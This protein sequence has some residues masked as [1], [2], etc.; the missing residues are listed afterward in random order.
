[1]APGTVTEMYGAGMAAGTVIS[2]LPLTNNIKGT[3]VLFGD[4][5]PALFF[6]S[7]GQLDIQTPPELTPGRQY[8]VIVNANGPPAVGV[9]D[10]TP[11]LESSASPIG[12]EPVV[13]VNE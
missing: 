10:R 3:S 4:R 7:P 11:E 6:V 13:T 8:N 9:P 12:S 5:Q 2:K 1:M